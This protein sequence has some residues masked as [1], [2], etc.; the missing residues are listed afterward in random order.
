M[1]SP[2]RIAAEKAVQLKEN[3]QEKIARMKGENTL[4]VP[5]LMYHHIGIP[6]ANEKRPQL[7]VEP[8]LFEKEMKYIADNGYTTITL[9]DLTEALTERKDLPQKSI[10]LTFDDGNLDF[11][12]TAFPILKQ[13]NLK[14]IIFVITGKIGQSKYLSLNQLRLM[15]NSSIISIGSHTVNH[16]KLTM[17]P[18]QSVYE[19]L[20]ASKK[21]LENKLSTQ[22]IYLAH[23]FGFYN[24]R[25]IKEAT[26]AG[27]KAAVSTD[28]GY[29]HM[30][31]NLYKLKRIRLGENLNLSDFQRRVS[32]YC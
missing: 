31:K 12:S 2:L 28:Y 22:N 16:H 30:R 5:I 14:A 25:I 4:R 3:I 6:P 8:V 11:Y 27:Y 9:D 24:S 18:S 20:S 10:I 7:Y 15:K 26:Q 29:L 32:V 21:F 19:E 13:Y 23:P 1:I 17:L